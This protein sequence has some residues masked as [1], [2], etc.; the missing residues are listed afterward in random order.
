LERWAPRACRKF[1]IARKIER[2]RYD[3]ANLEVFVSM[4]VVLI[5]G[6]PE[7]SAVSPHFF[8]VRDFRA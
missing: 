3:T 4:L 1:A 2:E 8:F 6:V 7:K 5:F